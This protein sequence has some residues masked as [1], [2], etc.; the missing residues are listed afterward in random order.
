MLVP[1]IAWIVEAVELHF[2]S[3]SY[4]VVN[5]SYKVLGL[6]LECVMGVVCMCSVVV[7]GDGLGCS[8]HT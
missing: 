5:M 6:C 2:K 1:A 4:D 7:V 8:R 3:S